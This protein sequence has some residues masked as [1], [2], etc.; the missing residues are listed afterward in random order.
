MK[1]F[2]LRE[3]ILLSLREEKGRRI[4]F[5]PQVTL[6]KGSNR[7]G[8]SCLIKSIYGSLG[9]TAGKVQDDWKAAKV[10]SLITIEVE[11]R[12]Y[13]ILRSGSRFALFGA[14]DSL[15][16]KYNGITREFGPYLAN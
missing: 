7:T 15:I 13:R 16:K 2:V 3:L 4:E 8:K 9:A 11:G 10:V 1:K 6:L 12:T 5:H 14:D